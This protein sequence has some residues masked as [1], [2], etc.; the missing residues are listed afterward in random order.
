MTPGQQEL[1]SSWVAAGVAGE[2][3][4]RLLA[5]AEAELGVPL[6]LV[7]AEGEPLAWTPHAPAGRH[8]LAVAAAAV[9]SHMRAPPGWTLLPMARGEASLGV[10][11]V[12]APGATG[13]LVELLAA[14]LG[15]QLQCAALK[16]ARVAAVVQRLADDGDPGSL[17]VRRDAADAGIRLAD[18]YWPALLAWREVEPRGVVLSTIRRESCAGREDVLVASLAGGMLLLLAV[19]GDGAARRLPDWFRD[20]ADSARR[21]AP[22]AGAQVIAGERPAPLAELGERVADLRAIARLQRHAIDDPVL[23]AQSF[24]LDRILT[25]VA[26][27]PEACQFV[28][29]ELGGL[30]RWDAEHRG[31]LLAVLEAALD[32]PRHE[33]AASHCYMHRNTFRHRLRHALDVLG[34]DLEDP[35]VRLAVHVALRLRRVLQQAVPRP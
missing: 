19:D 12:G 6:G 16:R 33:Q 5:L 27:G 2:D 15:D 18:A 24:A 17:S 34:R 8:A 32:Y 26:A 31:D 4:D 22:R 25:R 13:A 28:A 20:V 30:L 11:A 21:L 10:L 9:C 3:H 29:D 23:P 14:L 35:D 7:G 1:V